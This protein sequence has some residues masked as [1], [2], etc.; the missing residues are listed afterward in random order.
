MASQNADAPRRYGEF[1]PF[2]LREHS[3]VAT[4]TFHYVEISLAILC[5]N[6]GCG[7]VVIAIDRIGRCM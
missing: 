3:H 5:L 1:W 4:R 2:Y 6:L 7:N